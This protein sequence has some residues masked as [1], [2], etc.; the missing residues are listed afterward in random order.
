MKKYLIFFLVIVGVFSFTILSKQSLAVTL[1]ELQS[2]IQQ[3]L[4]YLRSQCPFVSLMYLGYSE[5]PTDEVRELQRL[6]SQLPGIYPEG[7]V[8]GYFGRL[9]DA[10]LRRFQQQYGLPITGQTDAATRAKLCEIWQNQKRIGQ[11][12]WCGADCVRITSGMN[13]PQ[14]TRPLGV[15]CKEVNGVCTKVPLVPPTTPPTTIVPTKY[16]CMTAR[17]TII[18]NWYSTCMPDP[19]GTFNSLEECQKV[20]GATSSCTDSDGGKNY[21]VKGTVTYN[22]QTYT[23]ACEANFT[24]N[25]YYCEN[26]VVKRETASCAEPFEC[27]DGACKQAT[28]LTTTKQ[29]SV[30]Y[31]S[32]ALNVGGAYFNLPVGQDGLTKEQ[33]RKAVQT[34]QEGIRYEICSNIALTDSEN[35]VVKWGDEIIDQFSAQCSTFVMHATCTQ[36]RCVR[37]PGAGTNQCSS[38]NDCIQSCTDSDGGRNYYVKG[39]VTYNGQTY[40]D[41]CIYC[42]GACLP[43][44][45]CTPNCYA[46]VEYYCENGVMKQETHGCTCQDGACKLSTTTTTVPPTP[47]NIIN[48]KTGEQFSINLEENASTGYKWYYNIADPSIV[49]FVKEYYQSQSTSTPIIVGAPTQHFWVFK[50]LKVGTTTITFTSRRGFSSEGVKTVVYTINV[51]ESEPVTS[52]TDS[53]GGRNYYVKGSCYDTTT[54]KTF[55]DYCDEEMGGTKVGGLEEV[56]CQYVP[57]GQGSPGIEG[58][59]VCVYSGYTCAYGC[60]N[61]A[62]LLPPKTSLMDALDKLSASLMSLMELLKQ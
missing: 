42:T 26:G 60:K 62:C 9:T 25:E 59:T 44:I 1:E 45:P 5:E 61:G 21:Y 55:Y 19:N 10:A 29:C 52:C 38:N 17:G 30:F 22:G 53:D 12:G 41:G 11:C 39:T 15:E 28:P 32:G 46:V 43:G 33:C 34:Y 48:I 37:T 6:L 35:I 57:I 20:C 13:C 18:S 2:Q 23:D 16:S 31:A 49:E 36:G 7:L 14:V 47:E 24:L 54:G 51:K 4:E 3:L 40:T 27:Q 58:K 56:N 8:T 50:G